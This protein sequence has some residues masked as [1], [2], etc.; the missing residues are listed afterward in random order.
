MTIIQQLKRALSVGLLLAASAPL[1][2]CIPPVAVGVRAAIPPDAAQT[3]DVQCQMIGMRLSAAAIM[4]GQVG[5]VCQYGP[6]ARAGV[7]TSAATVAGMA[8]I[9]L[10]HA[11]AIAAAQ[12][13]ARRRM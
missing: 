13:Q 7:D 9:M 12:A 2:S 3:C 11:Q 10:Q 1:A 4:A 6:Q 8:T 5:C